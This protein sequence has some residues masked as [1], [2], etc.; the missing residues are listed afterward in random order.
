MT[1]A[2]HTPGPWDVELD[3]ATDEP[4]KVEGRYAIHYDSDCLAETCGAFGT[5]E[6]ANARLIAAA[7]DLYEACLKALTCASLDSNVASLIRAALKKAR[8]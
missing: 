4:R 6:L 2:K 1:K 8:D 3:P 7:P 5:E